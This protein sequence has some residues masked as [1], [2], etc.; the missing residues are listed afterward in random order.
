AGIAHIANRI[1]APRADPL[2]LP[3]AA[4][5][6][7]LG[8][9]MI[10]R[11]D[12]H[13][14]A[15]QALWSAVGI[16]AYVVTLVV[17]RFSRDLARY[18]YLLGFGGV[19]LLLLPLV[20]HIGE[21]I[22][23]ARLWL[24][25]GPITFQPV[26]LAK[27]ALVIFFASYF[28][29]KREL[30]SVA[31]M[32]VGN[33][34]VPD[35]RTFGPIVAAW[36]MSIVIMVAE[37]DIGFS[38]LVFV[39]FITMLW[40]ATGRVAYL[41]IGAVLFVLA[42]FVAAHLFAQVHVRINSWFDPFAHAQGTGYQMVQAQYAMG[43]GGLAGTGLG[44]GHPGLIPVVVSDFIFAAFG[45]ELGLLG[46][47]SLV[48]AYVLMVTAG[49][50]IALRARTDFAKLLTAGLVGIFGFQ[51]FFIMAGVVRLLPLTGITLPF[52]AYGGSSLLANYI[53]IALVVRVSSEEDGSGTIRRPGRRLGRRT[54]SSAGI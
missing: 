53:L 1:L 2:I 33:R 47:T 23:G 14:A 52:V 21:N 22:N 8:Y 40:M 50:R 49:L 13:L 6:N 3:V 29:E 38:L 46:T 16:A 28:V 54:P 31:T 12:Y 17:V 5:L 19:F 27:I 42:A 41:V 4:L 39:I 20:P 36:G 34:L 9:V 30:L 25:L 44:L 35:P 11:L 51:A 43:T 24:R 45:E 18:R 10:A 7:G 15:L 48:I 26:E 37:H 32:R